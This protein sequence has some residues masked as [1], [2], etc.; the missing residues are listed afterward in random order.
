[1][2]APGLQPPQNRPLVGRV[3][4]P[5]VPISFLMRIAGRDQDRRLGAGAGAAP[6]PGSSLSTGAGLT[7]AALVVPRQGAG[8]GSPPHPLKVPNSGAGRHPLKVPNFI[9]GGAS[10]RGAT[11]AAV[12]GDFWIGFGWRHVSSAGFLQ[13]SPPWRPLPEPLLQTVKPQRHRGHRG[14]N[15]TGPAGRAGRPGEVYIIRT[16]D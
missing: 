11:V 16:Q 3:P 6:L 13:P 5:G 12:T 7:A 9:S 10:R 14:K 8:S 4:S 15:G 2:G 1:M